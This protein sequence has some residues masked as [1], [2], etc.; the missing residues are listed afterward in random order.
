MTVS[1][2]CADG[3]V[4]GLRE[5]DRQLVDVDQAE[6]KLATQRRGDSLGD[7]DEGRRRRDL[8]LSEIALGHD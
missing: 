8:E 3:T 4:T 6:A 5:R 2:R 1:V 7:R